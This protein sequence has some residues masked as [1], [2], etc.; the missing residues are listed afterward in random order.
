MSLEE[1]KQ[2]LEMLN[3]ELGILKKKNELREY[4]QIIDLENNI[5]NLGFYPLD[6]II[7]RCRDKIQIVSEEDVIDAQRM[8]SRLCCIGKKCSSQMKLVEIYNDTDQNILVIKIENKKKYDVT[9]SYESKIDIASNPIVSG[10]LTASH[11]EKKIYDN[12]GTRITVQR[13]LKDTVNKIRLGNRKAK[14][15]I[16]LEKH[17]KFI[18]QYINIKFQDLMV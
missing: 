18:S 11:N 16:F 2:E 9:T 12:D 1:K 10:G 3:I 15:I 6:T 5:N 17:K 14:L 4:Q 8:D 13:Y 7:V